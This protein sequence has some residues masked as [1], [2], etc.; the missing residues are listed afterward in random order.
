M[1]SVGPV[2]TM[3]SMF[4]LL[5]TKQTNVD[6]ASGSDCSTSNASVL[7]GVVFSSSV[8]SIFTHSCKLGAYERIVPTTHT[9]LIICVQ[10]R[11][12]VL[13]VLVV[14][15]VLMCPTYETTCQGSVFIIVRLPMCHRC[16]AK[17]VKVLSQV[18]NEL[19]VDCHVIRNRK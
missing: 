10:L 14:F 11:I 4:I 15:G 2:E 8:K 5:W 18:F 19:V 16:I 13:K 7:L 12:S 17:H 9:G 3:H 6:L 1:E